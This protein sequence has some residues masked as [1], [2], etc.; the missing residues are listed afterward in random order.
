MFRSDLEAAGIPYVV[1]GPDGPAFAD[2]HSLRHSYIALLDRSGATLKEAMQLARH[3]DPKLT[4]RIYGKLRRHDLAGAADRLPS[5]D[6]KADPKQR[7][8]NDHDRHRRKK[9]SRRS[10]LIRRAAMTYSQPPRNRRLVN[11]ATPRRPPRR[12]TLS[13]SNA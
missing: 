5:L 6:A 9:A 4:M 12:Q 1:E 10:V 7:K 13:W 3:S 11:S 2:F 8:D